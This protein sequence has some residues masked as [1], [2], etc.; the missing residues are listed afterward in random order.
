MTWVLGCAPSLPGESIGCALRYFSQKMCQKRDTT[1][2]PEV[3][4]YPTLESG[5]FPWDEFETMAREIGAS[6]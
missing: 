6:L 3:L 5:S 1:G 2:L 4:R